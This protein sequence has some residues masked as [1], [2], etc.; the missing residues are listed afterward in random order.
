MTTLVPTLAPTASPTAN[1]VLANF[2]DSVVILFAMIGL[3]YVSYGYRLMRPTLHLAGAV[4]GGGIAFA[5][6]KASFRNDNDAEVVCAVFGALVLGA[7]AGQVFE[8]GLFILGA[9]FGVA[10]ALVANT[11]FLYLSGH[12][13]P[14]YLVMGV[15]GVLWGVLTVRSERPLVITSTSCCGA[16]GVLLCV[17]HFAGAFPPPF[18]VLHGSAHA[19]RAAVDA[20][21]PRAWYWYAGGWCA[22]SLA[23]VA[24]QSYVTGLTP[25]QRAQRARRRHYEAMA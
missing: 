12:T 5:V 24:L 16:Y 9:G 13:Y 15:L 8:L 11:S 17:G 10:V 2:T 6:A 1:V 21:V 20:A 19:S 18:R 4:A 7:A 3:M 25:E 14:L 23:G 22:L